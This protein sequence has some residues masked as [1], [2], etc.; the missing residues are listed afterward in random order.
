MSADGTGVST[1]DVLR[2]HGSAIRSR[3]RWLPPY[4]V[5]AVAILVPA[6]VGSDRWIRVLVAT[7]VYVVLA[8]GLNLLV[9]Y[10]GLLDLGFIAFFAIGAYF[11]SIVT[12]KVAIG[13]AG[14]E[15][16]SLWWLELIDLPIAALVAALCGAALG[17][18]T[19]RAR[20]D[21]LAIMTLALGEVVRQLAIN[22][23]A[24]TNGPFGITNV[25]PPEL[26]GRILDTPTS[27]Y[28]A[29][30]VI[31]IVVL[32]A[33]SRVTR[34]SVGRAWIAIREDEVVAAS[35]GIAPRRYKLLAYASGAACGGLIG[36]F[37][38]HM[39]QFINPDNF[40]LQ[41][42]MTLLLMVIVGGAGTQW[43]PVVGAVLWV[44][45]QEW[46]GD[47]SVVQAHPEARMMVLAVLLVLCLRLLPRGIAP[48]TARVRHRT[49]RVATDALR[50]RHR[51]R[52]GAVVLNAA[53][54]SCSFGGVRALE[55]V[56]LQ[57]RAGEVLGVIGPNGAGKTTLMNILSGLQRPDGGTVT[58]HGDDQVGSRRTP[59]TDPAS[60]APSRT[61]A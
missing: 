18:P 40:Q 58:L 6:V 54:V 44:V 32:V 30:L 49:D 1:V 47:L 50:P 10:T 11:T 29:A 46:A 7:L 5:L 20:S 36:A 27:L 2:G 24:L 35:V 51:A 17:Y 4:L 55:S 45:L 60:R 16:G 57:L 37:Y 23:V 21:Y 52:I 25:P 8:S 15:G 26:P 19:L 12:V 31:A 13:H 56:T 42:N 3:L 38:G 53:D 39:Q 22:W 59:S 9:G 14:L 48:L 41:D 34:S 33:I 43:G 28:Y 61:F